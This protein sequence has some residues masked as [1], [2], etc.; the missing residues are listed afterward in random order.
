MVDLKNVLSLLLTGFL[1][2]TEQWLPADKQVL[3]FYDKGRKVR[4]VQRKRD[5]I[6]LLASMLVLIKHLSVCLVF[7]CGFFMKL[8]DFFVFPV[9]FM[10][11]GLQK[12]RPDYVYL[13]KLMRLKIR[14]AACGILCH[15]VLFS[16]VGRIVCNDSIF[17]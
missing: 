3:L 5:L 17:V 2:E 11:L 13:L 8:Q 14:A 6:H 4:Y 16:C 7:H 12:I 1:E 9:S 15:V 10:N